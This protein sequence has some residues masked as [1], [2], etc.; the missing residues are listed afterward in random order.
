VLGAVAG[1]V[2]GGL[3]GNKVEQKHAQ[4][5]AAQNAAQAQVG[6]AEVIQM[7]QSHVGD[8]VIVTKI[9]TSPTVYH[10]TSQDVLTLKQNGVSDVV[11][12]ELMATAARYPRRVYADPGVVPV[13]YV[14]D[15]APPPV[16]VGVG[17]YGGPRCC[18]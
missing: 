5:A 10:L 9:R 17:V 7:V 14:V 15:P 1:G 12:N 18:H 13:G 2:T 3:I 4:E 8:S 6:M 11:I 16:A